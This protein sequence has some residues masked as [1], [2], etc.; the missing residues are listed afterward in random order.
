MKWYELDLEAKGYK[1]INEI[2]NSR[3]DN[4]MS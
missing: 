4:N 3:N 2:N 1:M